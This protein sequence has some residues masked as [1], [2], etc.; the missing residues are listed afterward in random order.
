MQWNMMHSSLH[1]RWWYRNGVFAF[2][3]HTYPP[4]NSAFAQYNMDQFTLAKIEGYEDQVS[5]LNII[6][7]NILNICIFLKFKI[8]LK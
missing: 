4:F 2:S 7:Q 6:S 1:L 5:S 8:V 3:Q